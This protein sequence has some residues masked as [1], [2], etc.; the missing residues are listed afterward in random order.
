MND[1]DS[2]AGRNSMSMACNGKDKIYMFGGANHHGVLNEMY[3]FNIEN[4]TWSNLS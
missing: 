4:N 1:Y 3:E 2:P